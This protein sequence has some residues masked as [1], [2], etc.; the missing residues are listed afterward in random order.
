MTDKP[1]NVL[2]GIIAFALLW[3][4]VQLTPTATASRQIQDVN[5]VKV[6]DRFI[7]PAVPVENQK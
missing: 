7:G 4:A 6:S 2:L 3:I 1:S 5:I